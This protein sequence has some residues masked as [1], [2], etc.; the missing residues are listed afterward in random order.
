MRRA[1]STSTRRTFTAVP[2][3]PGT[4]TEQTTEPE[5]GNVA[6]ERAKATVMAP[7]TLEMVVKIKEASSDKEREILPM[8]R[9]AEEKE[10]EKDKEEAEERTTKMGGTVQEETVVTATTATSVA[11]VLKAGILETEMEELVV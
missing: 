7:E 6:K 2:V 4:A 11:L 3:T 9:M 1:S 10:K 8:A 5:K